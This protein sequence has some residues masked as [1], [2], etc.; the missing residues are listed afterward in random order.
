[1]SGPPLIDQAILDDLVESIGIDGT[2]SVLEL[3]IVE[4]RLYLTTIV[5]GAARHE[6][7]AQSDRVRRAAHALKSAAG[8][9]GAAALSA[10]AAAVERE[11]A[12][13]GP[14][15]PGHV[16]VLQEC[17]TRTLDALTRLRAAR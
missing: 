13:S 16:A 4:G 12:A 14:G 2:R 15:L 11:A 9:I 1:M 7:A 17:A 8:Q 6:D 3:F 5:E 10:A